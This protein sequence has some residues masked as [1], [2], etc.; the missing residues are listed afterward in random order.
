MCSGD[1]TIRKAPDIWRRWSHKSGLAQH[2]Q[3]VSVAWRAFR[4]LAPGG[5][6]VYSTCTLNPVEDEAVVAEI[7]RRSRGKLT[8]VDCS[9][10][11]PDLIRS[12]GVSTWKV[13]PLALFQ[14]VCI[15]SLCV[16]GPYRRHHLFDFVCG[17]LSR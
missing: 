5:R 13:F 10:E 2:R 15:I 6:I 14:Y 3:Q 7:L 16:I 8:L 4:M 11:L 1:G 17:S 12:H 9:H